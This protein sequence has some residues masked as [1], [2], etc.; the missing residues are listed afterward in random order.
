MEIAKGYIKGPGKMNFFCSLYFFLF[1][2]D[3]IPFYTSSKYQPIWLW[4]H[5]HYVSS[6]PLPCQWKLEPFDVFLGH[7]CLSWWYQW[8]PRWYQ[9]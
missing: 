3:A 5:P 9:W 6:S 8:V 4:R 2:N 1:K 7:E